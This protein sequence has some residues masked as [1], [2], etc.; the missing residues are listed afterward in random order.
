MPKV[1]TA[2]SMPRPFKV[3]VPDAVLERIAA[4]LGLSEVG[5]AP[6]DDEPWRHGTSAP[7]LAELLDHWRTRFD[8]RRAEERLNAFPQFKAQVEDIEVHFYHVRGSGPAGRAIILTHGWPGSV[9]EFLRVIDRLAHPERFGGRAEDGFDI[10]V[11][12]LPGYGFSSRP[13]APIGPR[14][15]ATLWRRLMVDV[16]GY[17]HF[18]AQGGDWGAAVTSWLG[19]DH[20][21]VV[22]AIHVNLL[23]G[24]LDG[25]DS[26]E[27]REWQAKLNAVRALESGYA[28]EQ[29]TR[30]QTIG[31]AL[32][33]S[34]LGFAAWVVEKFQRWGDTHGD[35]ES[36]FDK[37]L[38]LTNIMIYLVNDAVTSAMWMYYGAD[39]EAARYTRRVDVP[40]AV[41]LF[42]AE[43]L[44]I[45][46]RSTVERLVNLQRWTEMPAGGHFAAL[47]E[48]EDFAN[49]VRAFFA[50]LDL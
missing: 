50:P 44:P 33:D 3:A 48:P 26:L 36:R 40:C 42:P 38:L 37:D 9:V 35:I 34:P 25:D 32:A 24:A 2:V 20:P 11:P 15:V 47:E 31:L 18:F 45:P 49:D 10:V 6:R 23:V 8:W 28:Q 16:L 12:S 29:A 5:Y 30:P 14:R 27:T 19:S 7:Y 43:F 4:R 17:P 1:T 21:D 46:P 22:S 13:A 39:Q 41:A